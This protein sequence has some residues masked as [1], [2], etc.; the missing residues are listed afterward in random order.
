MFSSAQQNLRAAPLQCLPIRKKKSKLFI[1]WYVIIHLEI[2]LKCRLRGSPVSKKFNKV[3]GVSIFTKHTR[4]VIT[5]FFFNQKALFHPAIKDDVP[6]TT[7]F[8]LSS[9][10]RTFVFPLSRVVVT[11]MVNLDS[12]LLYFI[13][14]ST[15]KSP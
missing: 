9:R 10:F 13:C 2:H 4:F 15:Q 7:P 3:Y 14:I 5:F 6:L 12:F 8:P 1:I 11:Q